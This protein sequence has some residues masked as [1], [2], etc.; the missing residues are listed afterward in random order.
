MPVFEVT[1][2]DTGHVQCVVQPCSRYV[3]KNMVCQVVS[4]KVCLDIKLLLAYYSF[5]DDQI[6]S[7]CFNRLEHIVILSHRLERHVYSQTSVL[8]ALSNLSEPL[9]SL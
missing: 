2:S 1:I 8:I 7:Q 4:C 6:V 9:P 3:Y 5:K